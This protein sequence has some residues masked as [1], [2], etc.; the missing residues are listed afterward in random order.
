MCLLSLLLIVPTMSKSQTN[1]QCIELAATCT[2]TLEK[3]DTIIKLQDSKIDILNQQIS[4]TTELLADTTVKLNE[5]TN[6]PWYKQPLTL[7]VSGFI[8]GFLTAK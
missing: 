7:I 6:P 4:Q 3:A 2:K 5:Y 8:V 1:N